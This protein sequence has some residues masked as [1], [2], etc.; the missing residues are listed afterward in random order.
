M[1]SKF[2]SSVLF[3]NKFCYVLFC[4]TTPSSVVDTIGPFGM[5]LLASINAF[6][7]AGITLINSSLLF[8]CHVIGLPKLAFKTASVNFLA[9][10]VCKSNIQSSFPV[11]VVLVKANLVSLGAQI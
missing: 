7:L 1:V 9:V 4:D 8:L 2:S 3:F 10:A 6:L 5:A 11:V